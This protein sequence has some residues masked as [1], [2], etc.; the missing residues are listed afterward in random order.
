MVVGIFKLYLSPLE[1]K[2][3]KKNIQIEKVKYIDFFYY[4]IVY[5]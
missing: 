1:E 3:Y 5:S 2:L 4:I